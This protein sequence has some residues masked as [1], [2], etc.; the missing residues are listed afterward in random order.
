MKKL[1][2]QIIRRKN[3]RER[4][5]KVLSKIKTIY[6]IENERVYKWNSLDYL[7]RWLTTLFISLW[8]NISKVQ[9]EV[10]KINILLLEQKENIK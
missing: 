9:E 10:Y 5:E 4:R 2:N 3:R 6:L 1:D 7:L 8:W